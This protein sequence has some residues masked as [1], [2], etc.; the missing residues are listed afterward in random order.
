VSRG[1][2]RAVIG[3]ARGWERYL[4]HQVVL[5]HPSPQNR[6]WFKKN[7]WFETNSLPAVRARVSEIFT[8]T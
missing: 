3:F 5:P 6:G 8:D 1:L 7:P 4:P 2:I